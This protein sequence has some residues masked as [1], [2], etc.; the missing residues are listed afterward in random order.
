[1]GAHGLEAPLRPDWM[2]DET[3][4]LVERAAAAGVLA[5]APAVPRPTRD[6]LEADARK[7]TKAIGGQ[8]G[9]RAILAALEAGRD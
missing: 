4:D 3:W 7:F 8:D 9:A 1:M 5:Q 2:D 6:E